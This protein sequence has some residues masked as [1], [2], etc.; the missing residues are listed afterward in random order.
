MQ[1]DHPIERE[2]LMAYLDGELPVEQASLI[3]GHLDI[4]RDCQ[5]FCA[6][7]KRLSN[8]MLTWQVDPVTIQ[9]PDPP[10]RMAVLHERERPWYLWKPL[11]AGVAVVF[12][13]VSVAIKV[14]SSNT[15]AQLAEM[16]QP[17]PSAALMVAPPLPREVRKQA[18]QQGGQQAG[19]A[20]TLDLAKA[21][22]P[23]QPFAGSAMADPI[24]ARSAALSIVAKDLLPSQNA[25]QQILTRH[26]G[27]LADMTLSAE[28]SSARTLNASLRVPSTDLDAT[29]ADLKTLG[30]VIRE[31]RAGEDVT[32]QSVD[33]DVRL[34]NARRREQVLSDLMQHRTAKLSD[35]L[36]V[37]RQISETRG[38][39]EQMEAQRKS[40][41]KRIEYAQIDL[42]ISEVYRAQ[43]DAGRS[44]TG[45][46]LENA[47]IE[48]IGA[49][50]D[51]FISLAV[52]LLSSGPVILV[53]VVVLALP[54][55]YL[56]RRLRRT[57]N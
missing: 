37:E 28:E 21:I 11:W 20:R 13:L 43:L 30:R 52:I 7:L 35:V 51:S 34:A 40:L 16:S 19:S 44:S 4:C 9:P 27:F 48:G 6:D 14:D 54:V 3:A 42:Q 23:R 8:H 57:R 5:A 46:R 47:A 12:V 2:D 53:W 1:T 17:Q 10:A 15:K 49:V 56:W 26:R 38:E 32:Q 18:G 55:W 39:I 50:K 29:I 45:A 25:I 41:D 31:S 36:E 33:L 24:I 22:V